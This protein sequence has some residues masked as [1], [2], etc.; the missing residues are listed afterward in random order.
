MKALFEP[1]P[2]P[3]ARIIAARASPVS[4]IVNLVERDDPRVVVELSSCVIVIS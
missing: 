2:A 4:Y 1:A 3:C